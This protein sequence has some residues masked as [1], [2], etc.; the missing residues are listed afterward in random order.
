MIITEIFRSI[1]GESTHAGL[2]CIFVRLTG[3]NLRCTW[4]D[5]AYAF[6]GG[7]KMSIEEILSRVEDLSSVVK[8][9]VSTKTASVRAI[10]LV[11]LTGGEPLLQP[12]AIPLSRRLLDSGYT[13]LIETSGERPIAKLPRGVI[14][15]VDVKCPDSGEPDTFHMENLEAMD[16]KDEIKFVISSRRDYE[17]AKD[18]THRHALAQRVHQVVFSPV[19]ADPEGTWPGMRAQDLAEWILADGLPVRLGLQLHK[20]IWHAATR[21]V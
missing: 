1:Q 12:D 21:G 3:C 17:F 4:C 15:I 8:K 9:G 7:T 2:P 20:F 5:T 18:F 19:H 6:H 14:K 16:D 11:E 13:V 10:S